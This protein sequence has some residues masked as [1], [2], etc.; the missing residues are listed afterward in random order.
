MNAAKRKLVF[1]CSRYRGDV[2]QN[3]KNAKEYCKQIISEGN[4]PIAPHLYFPQFLDDNLESERMLG[5]TCGMILLNRCDSMTIFTDNGKLSEG[6]EMECNYAKRIGIPIT[7]Y[8]TLTKQS[9]NL[10]E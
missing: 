2:E 6:M 1:V 7:I 5:I 8:N 3:L 10:Q 4:I 9:H